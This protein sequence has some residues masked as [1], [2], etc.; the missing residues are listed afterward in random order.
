MVRQGWWGWLGWRGLFGCSCCCCTACPRPCYSSGSCRDI[1]CSSSCCYAASPRPCY[2]SDIDRSSC[3]CSGGGCERAAMVR[4]SDAAGPRVPSACCRPAT[5]SNTVRGCKPEHEAWC[6]GLHADPC[7]GRGA[8]FSAIACCCGLE[9]GPSYCSCG[10]P[11][12]PSCVR[13]GGGWCVGVPEGEMLMASCSCGGA[14]E[15]R[16]EHCCSC[17]LDCWHTLMLLDRRGFY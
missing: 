5:A 1:C 12:C 4:P 3:S 2:S 17:P 16:R 15:R 13:V 14:A 9:A 11:A 6:C 7:S 8:L 10:L